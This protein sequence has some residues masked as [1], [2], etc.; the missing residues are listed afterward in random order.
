[1][2][3]LVNQQGMLKKL[4]NQIKL[5]KLKEKT[6]HKKL[7]VALLKARRMTKVYESKLEKNTKDS[8]AKIAAATAAV[9]KKLAVSITKK[10]KRVKA[11]KKIV[12]AVRKSAKNKT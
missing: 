9:Y 2:A 11:T 5:L 10:A 12:F 3:L 1:M 6:A 7:K 4:R 8:K